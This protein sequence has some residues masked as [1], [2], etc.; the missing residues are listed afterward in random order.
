MERADVAMPPAK[1]KAMSKSVA[2]KADNTATQAQ[3]S[4]DSLSGTLTPIYTQMAEGKPTAGS[5]A[6]NTAAGQSV[7]GSNAGAVG[8]LGLQAARTRNAAG[9]APAADLAARNA[10]HDLSQDALGITAQNQRAG[11]AGLTG[12]YGT[13]ANNALN[14]LGLENTASNDTLLNHALGSFMGGFGGGFGGGL[15]KGLATR[16]F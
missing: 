16:K 8:Q 7:G 13:N 15:G 3:N 11:L 2:K 9:F 14:A 6:E 1:G 4:A 5:I 12:L 10:G